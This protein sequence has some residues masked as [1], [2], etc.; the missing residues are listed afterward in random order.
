MGDK[1]PITVE[2]L[3]GLFD[4]EGSVSSYIPS[5]TNSVH[6]SVSITNT[7]VEVLKQIAE[8]YGGIVYD[9]RNKG[10]ERVSQGVKKSPEVLREQ[11][12][13]AA[14]LREKNVGHRSRV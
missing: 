6:L 12:F 2:Y 1:R 11:L 5:G 10:P 4:G 7:S 14:A 3:A 8:E 9:C 13:F